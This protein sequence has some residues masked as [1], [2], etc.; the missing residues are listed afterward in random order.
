M[1]QSHACMGQQGRRGKD[2]F[3]VRNRKTKAQLFIQHRLQVQVIH[4]EVVLHRHK[5]RRPR[6]ANQNAVFK[7]QHLFGQESPVNTNVYGRVLSG[8]P[9]C[10]VVD[11]KGTSLQ[12]FDAAE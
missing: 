3:V 7:Q 12:K 4:F 8:T 1:V 6:L 5:S 2:L 11:Y 9:A 10:R